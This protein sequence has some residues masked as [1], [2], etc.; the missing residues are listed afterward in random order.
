MMQSEE[1]ANGERVLDEAPY[2]LE[3]A[4]QCTDVHGRR[5]GGELRVQRCA[6]SEQKLDDFGRAVVGGNVKWREAIHERHRHASA[7]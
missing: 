6:V 3:V 4:V 5:P 7:C 2:G 1:S